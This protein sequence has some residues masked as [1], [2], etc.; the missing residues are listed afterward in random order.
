M[1]PLYEHMKWDLMAGVGGWGQRGLGMQFGGLESH[2]ITLAHPCP[3]SEVNLKN[4][5]I[6]Y[7]LLM[8]AG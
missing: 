8:A 5:V 2:H 7:R 4:Q 3:L 6:S 1:A